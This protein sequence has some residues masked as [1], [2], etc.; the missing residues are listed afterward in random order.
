MRRRDPAVRLIEVATAVAPVIR[1]EILNNSL[2][3]HTDLVFLAS[4]VSL[5]L[6]LHVALDRQNES[7]RTIKLVA[8]QRAGTR[9]L[10]VPHDLT[11]ISAADSSHGYV[12]AA[13]NETFVL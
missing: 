5:T 12:D 3:V 7:R 8:R 11:S 10:H 6:G 2:V 1:V 13:T 9:D 4:G